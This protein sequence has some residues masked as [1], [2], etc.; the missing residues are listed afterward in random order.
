VIDITIQQKIT[1][2]MKY[3]GITQQ[4][5]ADAFG[6]SQQAMGKRLKTGKF[7]IAELEKI[8]KVMEC[9]Y[10]SYFEFDENTRI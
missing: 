8:A 9:K 1:A 7:T 2:A 6:I 4:Q 10:I 3:K 5:L